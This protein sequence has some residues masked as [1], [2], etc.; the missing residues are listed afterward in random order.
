MR[1]LEL[2]VGSHEVLKNSKFFNK[3]TSGDTHLLILIR[4]SHDWRQLKLVKLYKQS[5]KRKDKRQAPLSNLNNSK[6]LKNF[7][8]EQP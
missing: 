3:R 4:K 5:E 8:E 1:I 6:F 7:S 2:G